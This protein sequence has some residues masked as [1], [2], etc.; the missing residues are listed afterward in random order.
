VVY[1][2]AS[3][4]ANGIPAQLTNPFRTNTATAALEF[5]Y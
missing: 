3:I 5:V 2:T 4:G 1:N